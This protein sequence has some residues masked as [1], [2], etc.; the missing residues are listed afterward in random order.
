MTLFECYEKRRGALYSRLTQ[1]KSL[2]EGAAALCDSLDAV[3]YDYAN[4]CADG[5][6]RELAASMTSAL[7]ASFPLLECASETKVWESSSGAEKVKA[8]KWP[9]VLCLIFGAA[10][11][12]GVVF[13]F[14]AQHPT[15]RVEDWT[16]WALGLAF[17]SLLLFLSGVFFMR[18]PKT[19]SSAKTERKVDVSINAADASRRLAA[20]VLQMDKNLEQR[21]AE[22]AAK[23]AKEREG[24]LPQDE[25][26]L[27]VSLLEGA[28]SEDGE[29]ALDS[30]GEVRHYLARKGV[31][32]KEYDG[33]D[34]SG[35]ELL[36]GERAAT[37][38][39]ALLRGGR[40]IK[41]GLATYGEEGAR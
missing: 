23:A 4:G 21:R 34:E 19:I 15:W 41:K 31:E 7:K 38:R 33:G 14:F 17:G 37:L 6:L 13:I 30:L 22:L 8:P 20:V 27:M 35:F 26:E 11:T 39:P 3:L 16:S 18:S 10:V 28:Y 24:G 36:P 25:L 12:A 29:L 2:A 5:E 32:I 9:A 1:A 40:L